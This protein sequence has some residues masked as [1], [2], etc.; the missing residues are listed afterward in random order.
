[1]SAKKERGG[2]RG[3][4]GAREGEGEGKGC[5]GEESKE[6]RKRLGEGGR[7]GGTH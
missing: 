1:M 3:E 7:G 4:W 6:Q 5:I 2:G